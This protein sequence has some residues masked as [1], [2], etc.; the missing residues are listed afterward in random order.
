[1]PL[2][3]TV[4][5]AVIGATAM[6]ASAQTRYKGYETPR[7][8]VEHREGAF[9]LRSYAPQLVAEVTVDGNRSGAAGKAFR[10]LADFIFGGN[11]EST[12]IAMTAPVAQQPDTSDTKGRWTVRFS[13]PAS[14]T[15]ASL[16]TPK[17]ARI[18]IEE[19][20]PEHMAVVTFSG[21][22]QQ[23]RLD[24]FE[25]DLRD[26]ARAQGLTPVGPATYFFYDDPFTLP[27]KRRNEVAL[28]LRRP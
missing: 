23:A 8:Q 10:V 28:T 9:E 17:D 11:A 15:D 5:A 21:R 27:W 1:M 16:P 25:A 18:Q 2:K 24:A 3:A 6:T 13:M 20:A 14:F 19:R 12:K 7:Y 26:W 4:L 22:W